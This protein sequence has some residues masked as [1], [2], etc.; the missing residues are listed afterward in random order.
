MTEEEALEIAKAIMTEQDVNTLEG[1]GQITMGR[2]ER[3]LTD[4][5][6]RG[7]AKARPF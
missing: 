5:A 3:M 7:A 2:I 6:Q 1:F 4:A